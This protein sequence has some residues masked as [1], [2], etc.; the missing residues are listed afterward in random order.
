MTIDNGPEFAS[1][2]L[3]EEA[4]HNSLKL[5]LIRPR[6]LLENA[7]IK[8]FID[9]LRDEYLNENWFINLQHAREVTEA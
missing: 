5:N 8:S 1:R 2:Y 9:S 7:P 4:Y 3:E 6:K